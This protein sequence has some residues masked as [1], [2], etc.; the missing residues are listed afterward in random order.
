VRSPEKVRSALPV[1]TLTQIKIFMLLSRHDRRV[2][3]IRLTRA[4]AELIG[5]IITAGAEKHRKL[6]SH[7]SAEELST[8]AEAMRLLLRAADA[9]LTEPDSEDRADV[10]DPGRSC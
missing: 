10:R 7:L 5:G 4:G 3:R 1:C 9:L 2:R 8:V 6:L